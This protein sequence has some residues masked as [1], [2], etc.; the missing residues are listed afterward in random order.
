VTTHKGVTRFPEGL[1]NKE[2]KVGVGF[3]LVINIAKWNH[4]NIGNVP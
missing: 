1:C 3:V 4:K 2:G